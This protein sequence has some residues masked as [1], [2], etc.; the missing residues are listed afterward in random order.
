MM[1][2]EEELVKKYLE[3]P[4]IVAM[5]ERVWQGGMEAVK[6]DFSLSD[7]LKA[8]LQRLLGKDV[9]NIF[10]TDSDARHIKKNH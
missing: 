7:K 9:K 6:I 8:E 5:A 10:I 4:L 2:M 3:A 1:D